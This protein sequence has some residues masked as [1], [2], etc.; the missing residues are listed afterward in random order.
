MERKRFSQDDLLVGTEWLADHLG[1]GEIRLVEVTPP[2]TGYPFGHLPGAVFLNLDEVFTGGA[3]GVPRAVGPVGEV[4]AVLGRLGL[5]PDKRIVIYDEIGGQ[6]AAQ[7]FWLLEYLGFG[8]A[9]VLEGG[10][11]RWMVEGRPLT[12]SE[13]GVEPA[14]FVPAISENRLA[15]AEWIASRLQ[16]KDVR[17]VDCRTPEEYQA[18]HIPGA[19]NRSWDGSL[20]LRAHH[21]FRDADEL[22]REFLDL[23]VTEGSEIVTY[24]NTGLRSAHTYLTL[25]LLGY[26]RVRNYV[27][28]WVEWEQKPDLPKASGR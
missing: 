18:G 10:V 13:P 24:C 7:A 17:V 27:G 11:E 25:R 23:E 15:T 20:A 2:G 14:T 6:N 22:R 1:D 26:P 16:A 12:S 5:V 28:S 9:A 3:D 19:C 4:V 8:R 21:A